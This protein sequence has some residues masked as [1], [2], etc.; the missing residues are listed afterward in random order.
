[1][2]NSTIDEPLKPL[3]S[4]TYPSVS[5]A[6]SDIQDDDDQQTQFLQISFNYGP[7]PY[8]DIIFVILFLVFVLSTF[9]FGIFGCVNRNPHH[10]QQASFS[11]NPTTASC[12]PEDPFFPI[13]PTSLTSSLSTFWYTFIWTLV[14]TLLLSVPFLLFLLFLLNNFTKQIVY[15][16]LPFCVLVP[17]LLNVYWFIACTVTSTC[18]DSFPL[19]Y[20]ILML[21]FVFLII[22]VL[23]WILV[24]NWHRVELTVKIIRVASNALSRNLLLLVVLPA[25]TLGLLVYYAP[26]VVFLVFAQL[27]GEIVPKDK[28]GHYYCVWKQDT[29]VPAYYTLAIL[30]MLWSAAALV[31]AKVFVISGTIAQWYFSKEDDGLKRGIRNALRNAFGPSFGTICF[32][33]LLISTIRVVRFMVDSAREEGATG[34][35]NLILRCCV[36]TLLSAFDFLNKFTINFAAIT[37]EA[38]CSSARMTYELLKRNLL[39]VVF[40]ETVSA[41]VLALIIF[42]FSTIYAIVVCIILKTVIDLGDDAYIV[43][44]TAWL[45]LMVV[46]GYFVLVLDSVI[47]TVYVCY[48]IDRDRGEVCKQEVH[49]VYGHLPISRSDRSAFGIRS[50]LLV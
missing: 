24:V 47:D 14:I 5:G 17:I 42:V 13:N 36:N 40:V 28:D 49:E 27:N 41:R 48:A 19:P 39:S 34:I 4:T 23:V 44:V 32:S 21:V 22:G 38:Y 20:R 3:L 6:T 43:A 31:E 33:G 37:G 45:L 46:F 29:W 26:I 12:I 25:L 10:G 1:M 2:A 16:S 30:T 18:S 11:Y 50:P 15:V 8:Q 35:V 7:R 9:G